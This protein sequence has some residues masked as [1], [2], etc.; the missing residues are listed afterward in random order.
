VSS[1]ID[2][3]NSLILTVLF[4]WSA[5]SDEMT[6]LSF[7]YMLLALASIVFLGSESFATIFYCLRSD[8][9]H[10]V[11]S[12]DSQAGLGSF[13]YSPEAN[14]TG[15]TVSQQNFHCCVESSWKHVYPNVLQRRLY[16]LRPVHDNPS[17]ACVYVA[18]IT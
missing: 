3:Y 8:I 5:L 7:L 11:A 6:A 18:G 16:M 14:Q 15:N 9:S 12:Y 1:L 4:L 13:S 2:I 10:F 17:G